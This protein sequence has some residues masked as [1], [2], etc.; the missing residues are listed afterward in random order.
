MRPLDWAVLIGFLLFIPFLVVDLV[1]ANRLLALGMHMLS[2]TTVSLPFKLIPAR[3]RVGNIDEALRERLLVARRA[4]AEGLPERYRQSIEFFAPDRYNALF[5]E[6]IRL[7]QTAR[8]H[9]E[10]GIGAL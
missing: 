2:P 8:S 6:L 3:H 5:T 4:F 10:R 7:E 1:I 9:R